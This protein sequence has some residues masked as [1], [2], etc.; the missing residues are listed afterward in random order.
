MIN[1]LFSQLWKKHCP[2]KRQNWIGIWY[3][4]FEEALHWRVVT[5]H[6]LSFSLNERI[7]VTWKWENDSKFVESE[8]KILVPSFEQFLSVYTAAYNLP[9]WWCFGACAVEGLIVAPATSEASSLCHRHPLAASDGTWKWA[10]GRLFASNRRRINAGKL[11]KSFQQPLTLSPS[12]TLI[13]HA[14]RLII[15]IIIIIICTFV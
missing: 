8:G 2:R 15:I 9:Y 12:Q 6:K 1:R 10:R 11:A 4:S 5:I 14:R 7:I 13:A 3:A